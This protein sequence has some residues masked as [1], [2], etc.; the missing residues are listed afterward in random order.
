MS[1]LKKVVEK[2]PRKYMPK[3][4]FYEN[5]ALWCE[6]HGVSPP[7]KNYVGKNLPGILPGVKGKKNERMVEDKNDV[8]LVSIGRDLPQVERMR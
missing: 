2:D 4:Y 5:L 1:S 8:G 6:E 7:S 3:N